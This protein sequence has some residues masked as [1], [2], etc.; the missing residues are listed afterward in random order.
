MRL[1]LIAI[2]LAL[3]SASA[4]SQQQRATDMRLVDAGFKMRAAITKEQLEHVKKLPPRRFIPREEAGRRYYLYA[5]PDDCQCVFAG[6][7][8]ALKAYRDM[9]SMPRE[10]AAASRG[11]SYMDVIIHDRAVEL[12]QLDMFNH[13]F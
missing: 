4:F 10:P 5:D 11:G 9:V 3:A 13:P 8:L 1:V 12:P 7:E 6:D 2:T